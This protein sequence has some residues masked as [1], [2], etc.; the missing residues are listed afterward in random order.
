MAGSSLYLRLLAVRYRPA[1]DPGVAA[2]RAPAPARSSPRSSAS[3]GSSTSIL[4]PRYNVAPSE[5]IETII[6]V[7]DEKRLGPTRWGLVPKAAKDP[8][9]API[10]ARAET[11]STSPMFRD[12]FRRHRCLVV[13]DGFYE[14]R[15]DGRRKTPFFIRLRSSRPFAFAGIWSLRRSEVGSRSAT[16]AIVTCPPNELMAAIHDRMPVIL[17]PGARDRWLDPTAGEAELR[18]RGGAA[19][20]ACSSRPTATRS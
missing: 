8:K 10:N 17:S 11:L 15:K 16:C 1:F 7:G 5:N 18:G 2:S 12:A 14:W 4:R 19:D 9:L 6:R 3:R 13:A 20:R